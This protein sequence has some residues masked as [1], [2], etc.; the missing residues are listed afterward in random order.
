MLKA[1][2][3]DLR[4]GELVGTDSVGNKYYQNNNYFFGRNRWVF[5]AKKRG[6]YDA[7]DVPAEWHGWLHYTTDDPP[8]LKPPTQRKFLSEHIAN[9]TGSNEA[10]VPYSTTR[11][12][13]QSWKPPQ[14]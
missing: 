10:Y 6:E 12:K 2:M 5:Y 14:K 8:T 13:V 9:K 4:I 7:S 11:P 1:R 3:R